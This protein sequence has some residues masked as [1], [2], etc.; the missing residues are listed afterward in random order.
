MQT[1][2]DQ[3]TLTWNMT[4][5]HHPGY[6]QQFLAGGIAD[7]ASPLIVGQTDTFQFLRTSVSP[8]ISVMVHVIDNVST[9][10]NRT[11]VECFM[12]VV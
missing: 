7:R 6:E 3:M 4:F 1:M 5:P 11:R 2:S 8:L 9:V 10:L 12:M